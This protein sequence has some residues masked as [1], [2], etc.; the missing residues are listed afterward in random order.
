M[1]HCALSGI[2]VDTVVSI[3]FFVKMIVMYDDNKIISIVLSRQ[4]QCKHGQQNKST[5][6]QRRPL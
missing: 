6:I 1:D 4:R 5:T 2:I 3:P